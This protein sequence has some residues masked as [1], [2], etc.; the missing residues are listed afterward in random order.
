MPFPS[1]ILGFFIICLSVAAPLN[2]QN[3]IKVSAPPS[4]WIQDDGAN[5]KGPIIDIL[6]D[7]FA[8]KGISLV[9]DKLPWARAVNHMKTG[10]LDLIPVI[11]HT[12]EREKIMAFSTPYVDVPTVVVV[13]KGKSFPF[14]QL[15]DL[16]GRQGLVVR[17]DSISPEFE[18][19]RKELNLI[20]VSDYA[21]ILKMLAAGRVDYAVCP[22]YGFQIIAKQLGYSEDV[23]YLDEPV[24]SREIHIAISRKSPFLHYLPE[25]NIRLHNLK[26]D[27]SMKE[28][29]N[30]ALNQAAER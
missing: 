21:K 11:F 18:V 9:T 12:K 16:I 6:A 1:Q 13:A 19:F 20:E 8:E 25:I 30:R 27:G 28:I 5:L 26:A 22:K 7:L 3:T 24:A 4:I 17:G 23:E 2:A 10:N 29:I 15:K 14:T